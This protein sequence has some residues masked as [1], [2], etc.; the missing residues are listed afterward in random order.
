MPIEIWYII[1]LLVMICITFLFLKRPIYECM[2][3]GYI[4][5][6]GLTGEWENVLTYIKK[7]STD[8]LFYAIVAFLVLAKI[9]D[10]TGAVNK[11]VAPS[12]FV[13]LMTF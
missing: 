10:M 12:T 1:A 4:V 11:I 9:L 13:R 8:T 3:Y 7:T 6:I 5:M 2:L